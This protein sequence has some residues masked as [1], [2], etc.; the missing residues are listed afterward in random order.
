MKALDAGMDVELP[1]TDC[2]GEP[3]LDA[4]RSGLVS[5][6]DAR[7]AR[8]AACCG[9]SSSSASSS[10]RSSTRRTTS[11]AG[12]TAA[13]RELARE[14]AR[15]SLVLLRNDGTLPL[16]PDARLRRASSAR[17]RTT[18]ATCFGD[19]AYPAHVESLRDVLESGEGAVSP[20]LLGG[21]DI[22]AA[23]SSRRPFSTRSASTSAHRVRFERGCEVTGDVARRLRRGG[24]ARARRRRRG[25]GD[26][27]QV[28][29]SPSDCTSGESRDCASLDLP[30][31]QEE[32]IARRRSRPERRSCSCS[33]PAGRTAARRCTSVRGRAARVASGR[34]GRRRD[35]RDAARRR[36]PRRQ[37]ARSPIPA[38]PDRSR[39]STGTRSPA[40]ARTGRATT[41]TVRRRRSTRSATA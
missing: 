34:G 24:R 13:Q 15:K 10:S 19:Y 25:H 29:V 12:D 32:L 40:A 39:S 18:C 23:R 6:R 33:S 35:R 4:V 2:Y 38:R 17:A 7:R 22:A 14:I 31:V 5:D 20:A 11:A 30:G 41:S 26:G 8:F 27:R 9:R 28:R 1:S 37:A 21:L 36:E 16:S 3:L